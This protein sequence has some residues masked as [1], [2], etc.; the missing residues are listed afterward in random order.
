MQQRYRMERRIQVLL[1]TKDSMKNELFCYHNAY[2][3]LD[4]LFTTEINR[5]ETDGQWC[6]PFRCASKNT[7]SPDT[8]NH[9]VDQ[10]VRASIYS[11]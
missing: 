8:Q 1:K 5:A 9:I 6:P 2:G 4:Y 11:M 3:Y 10:Y 7:D